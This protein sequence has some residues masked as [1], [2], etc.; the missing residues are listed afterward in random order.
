[1][2]RKDILII[3]V[4]RAIYGSIVHE[5]SYETDSLAEVIEWL[6]TMMHEIPEKCR[7]TAEIELYGGDAPSLK[8]SYRRPET[9]EETVNRRAAEEQRAERQRQRDLA[10]YRHLKAKLNL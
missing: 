10:D 9:A 1:M 6:Q 3:L 4:D 7:D 5:D 2:A 8:I